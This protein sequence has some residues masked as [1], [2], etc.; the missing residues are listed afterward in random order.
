MRSSKVRKFL[1]VL[2]IIAAVSL[3][4]ALAVLFVRSQY[5]G[6]TF[7]AFPSAETADELNNPYQGFY[8]IY[9][10]QLSNLTNPLANLDSIIEK[11]GDQKLV[12]LEINLNYYSK[13]KISNRGLWQLDTILSKWSKT[14]KQI[15]LRFLYDWDGKNQETEPEHIDQV[16]AHM[17][18]VAPIV[19]KYADSIYIMQGI[20]VGN[21]GE[22][23][24]SRHLSSDNIRYLTGRLY[25]LIDPSIF[26]SVR[27]PEHWRNAVGYFPSRGYFPKYNGTLASRLGLFN[28]GMLGSDTDL[29]TYTTMTREE[30]LDFQYQICEYVPNGGE[31]VIDNPYNDLDSAI[32]NLR[33]MHVSYLNG[34]YDGAVMDKWR[35]TT[36]IGDDCF[37]GVDGYTYI[38]EH[39]GYRYVIRST[40]IQFNTWFDTEASFACLMENVGFAPCLRILSISLIVENVDSFNTYVFPINQDIRELSYGEYLRLTT[41]IPIRE[42]EKGTYRIYLKIIDSNTN[43]QIKFA[44]DLE[45]SEKGVALGE[46][47][48]S[49]LLS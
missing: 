31:V 22:M 37:N 43:T 44:T 20:F 7:E 13:S 24:N 45:Q 36:Y 27:T 28:D 8:T 39:L 10:Y 5:C 6:F 16:S 32:Q 42:Y 49:D 12:L 9:G 48:V 29:G 15:I 4:I 26:L 1:F 30:A 47:T 17:A 40:S 21:Y 18:Q 25:E 46:F 38:K 3:L 35:N 34:A 33:K 2:N 14:D 19:N 41:T 23:N 11:S